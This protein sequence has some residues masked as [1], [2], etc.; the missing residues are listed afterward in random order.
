MTA[1]DNGIARRNAV[2]AGCAAY[3]QKPASA[4]LLLAAIAKAT[5]PSGQR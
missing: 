2:A 1:A 3:L 5:R 4:D